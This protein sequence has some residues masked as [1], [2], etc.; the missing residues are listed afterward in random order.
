MWVHSYLVFCIIMNL[1]SKSKVIPGFRRHWQKITQE[2]KNHFPS[3]GTWA[4]QL[5]T[6]YCMPFP[7]AI[8]S[9]GLKFFPIFAV[10]PCYLLDLFWITSQ[11][12]FLK[13]QITELCFFSVYLEHSA[14]LLLLF[15]HPHSHIPLPI[16]PVMSQKTISSSFHIRDTFVHKPFFIFLI[17]TWIKLH[18]EKDYVLLS[19]LPKAKSLHMNTLTF[20]LPQWAVNGRCYWLIYVNV[21]RKLQDTHVT[22]L[23]K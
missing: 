6:L 22:V 3:H 13:F 7:H 4:T 2:F 14:L 23:S 5:F 8:V 11:M 12:C 1:E 18:L 21:N 20:S 16:L 19:A 15:L 10:C 17:F 9:F